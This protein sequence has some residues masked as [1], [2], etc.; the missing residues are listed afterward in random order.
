MKQLNPKVLVA[1]MALISG[2]SISAVA[3]YYSVVGLTA[4]F[5]AAVIPIIV[6][7]TTLEIS[8]LVA[9]VWLKQNW[10]ICPRTVKAYL[11]A[12]IAVLMLITSMGI[13]GF[14]SKA[15][16]DQGVPTGDV[17]A[18]VALLDEKIK[19]EKD[20]IDANKKA[21]TQMD[22]QVDQLLGRTTDDKGASKAVQ[23]RK[24]QAKERASL[25]ADIAKSQK[26]VAALNE[27]RAPIA[28]ELRKVEAEVGPIKYI[29][30]FFYGSTDETILEK[31]VTW[32]ILTLIVVFD[33]LAV[34]LLLAS[35][36]SFQKMQEEREE[37]E[38]EKRI[39]E[40]FDHGK[41]I[42]RELDKA[43]EINAGAELDQVKEEPKEDPISLW[44]RMID[45]AALAVKDDEDSGMSKDALV[46]P[47]IETPV[48]PTPEPTAPQQ[49]R[50]IDWESIPPSQ[51]YILVDGQNMSVKAAKTL[52]PQT[53]KPVITASYV[54]N[55][56]QSESGL[57]NQISEKEYQTLALE[58]LKKD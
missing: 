18:K 1:Y 27:E 20:N 46:E 40:F 45:M 43:T 26:T 34:I 57:W 37:E 50:T 12:A 58:K 24:S 10:T 31:A 4:I 3:V 48:E 38:E 29:A 39:K 14:L 2:L 55:E 16:L 49:V 22:A 47:I 51:E 56:E 19:T 33:P 17:A 9:T 25:Q 7:G 8:K 52:Y 54:Q 53:P 11:L 42:A 44:N 41:E 6:M 13:F 21:L 15:H 5:A 35:Q 28:S 32:V 23:I 30:A 36:I